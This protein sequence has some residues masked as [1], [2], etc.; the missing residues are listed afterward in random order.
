MAQREI[1]TKTGKTVHLR[2]PWKP[3]AN[4][5]AA[6][7]TTALGGT[8]N[9]K[10][11]TSKSDTTKLKVTVKDPAKVNEILLMKIAVDKYEWKSAKE[12]HLSFGAKSQDMAYEME[13]WVN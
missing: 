12:I 3:S 2:T 11:I 9:I 10:S 4:S 7:I 13:K 8:T 6:G 5:I 1:K